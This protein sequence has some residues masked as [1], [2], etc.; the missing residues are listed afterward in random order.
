MPI[1]NFSRAGYSFHNNASLTHNY[2]AFKVAVDTAN[3]PQSSAVPNYCC[4][5]S[6]QMALTSISAGSLSVTAYLA[7]HSGGLNILTPATT[8]GATQA[9]TYTSGTAVGGVVFAV[10]PPGD[11]HL[12]SNVS[13]AEEGA[14]YVVAKLDGVGQTATADITVNWRA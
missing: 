13:N 7:R 11:Y 2:A 3:S 9:I 14:L 5:Q 4:V 1:Q 12:D 6:V 10:D 8:S